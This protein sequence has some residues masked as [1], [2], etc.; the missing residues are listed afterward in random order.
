MV[1]PMHG[2][3]AAAAAATP[4][5]QKQRSYPNVLQDDKAA[6]DTFAI[7]TEL[8]EHGARPHLMANPQ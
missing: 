3:F 1:I 4:A 6:Q 5:Y 8:R 2:M 7:K